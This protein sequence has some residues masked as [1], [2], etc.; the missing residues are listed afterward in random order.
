MIYLKFTDDGKES[1]D[2]L[3]EKFN[4]A[5]EETARSFGA[6]I[7]FNFSNADRKKVSNAISKSGYAALPVFV[8]GN[9]ITCILMHRINPLAGFVPP[10]KA[11]VPVVKP[12]FKKYPLPIETRF[13]EAVEKAKP[14]FTLSLVKEG[15]IS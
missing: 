14:A 15:P 6:V 3:L 8:V 4:K 5:R 2:N 11:D 10:N 7:E 1:T 9:S 13:I 12:E